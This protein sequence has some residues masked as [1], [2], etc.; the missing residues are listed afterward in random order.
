ML[1]KLAFVFVAA[2]LCVFCVSCA[3]TATNSSTGEKLYA[4]AQKVEESSDLQKASDL[5]KQ[6][7]DVLVKEGKTKQAADCRLNWQKIEKITLSYPLSAESVVKGLKELSPTITENKIKALM[8]KID[9][10]NL[11]GKPYYFSGF[12]FTVIGLDPELLYNN[13]ELIANY[14]KAAPTLMK[15]VSSP[16][17]QA[18]QPY[19]KPVTYLCE[20]KLNIPRGK[21]PLTGTF[22]LW[23]P[24][25]VLTAAQNNVTVLELSP[26]SN[27][28]QPIRTDNEIGMAYLEFPLDGRKDAV[29]A[30]IKFKFTHFEQHFQAVDPSRVG[31]YNKESSL[32]KQYT[33]SGKNVKISGDIAKTA[34]EIAGSETNPYLI[35]KKIYT[36][37]VDQVTYSLM[38]H[39]ALDAQGSA[40]SVYVHEHRFGDC[41]A[42][43]AYFT[44]L[45]RAVGI[46][47]RTSGGF[48]MWAMKNGEPGPHFWAEFYLPNY[49]WLPIDTS[50]A[51]MQID[52]KPFVSQAERD[53]FKWFF[54]A[55]QD[56]ARCVLQKDV[57]A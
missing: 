7:R 51:Q 43:S 39:L 16:N 46:P 48:Q 22:K 34:R 5:Y 32:Y 4:E 14:K 33:A 49:G 55:N 3:N 2:L 15:L 23:I 57:D 52:F 38:P 45:C 6:A 24:L 56:S 31:E 25:P 47:A 28:K 30:D 26:S 53:K 42:Q 13:K 12:L 18:W 50:A 10:I 17:S 9:H 35:A 11:A 8:E 19:S 54:F 44:S 40:E 27:C 41:G 36:Y 21:L 1:K 29:K 20:G 37:V